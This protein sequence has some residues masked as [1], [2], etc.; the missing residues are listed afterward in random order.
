MLKLRRTLTD[1]RGMGHRLNRQTVRRLAIV[2]GLAVTFLIVGSVNQPQSSLAG[3]AARM[4][5]TLIQRTQP[6][7][8]RSLGTLQGNTLI[9]EA[10][11][12]PREPLYTL[13]SREGTLLATGL[14]ATELLAAH[15]DE[16]ELQTLLA[17]SDQTG[18]EALMLAPDHAGP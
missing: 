16:P 15:P 1:R 3:S 10:Y 5:G 14:T 17:G 8:R 4:T 18:G 7:S 2:A 12:G 13:R 9:L 6:E 11:A